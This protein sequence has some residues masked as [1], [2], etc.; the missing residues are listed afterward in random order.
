[1]K[2]EI[3]DVAYEL[4]YTVNSVCDLEDMTGKG[5]GDILGMQGMTSVRA[6]LWAGLTEHQ[7]GLTMRKAGTLLQEYMKTHGMDELV[8]AIGEA[9]KQ[10]GFMTAQGEKTEAK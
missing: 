2:I 7:N 1:M 5:L 6:L 3:G 4:E 9:I 10:A 8:A